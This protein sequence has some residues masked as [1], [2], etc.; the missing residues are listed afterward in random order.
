MHGFSIPP[1]GK[2]GGRINNPYSPHTYSPQIFSAMDTKSSVSGPNSLK[3]SSIYIKQD[4]NKKIKKMPVPT[5]SGSDQTE[6]LEFFPNVL[7]VRFPT[8]IANRYDGILT[9]CTKLC[10][11]NFPSWLSFG[12]F[13]F[14][15]ADMTTLSEL[16]TVISA[17]YVNFAPG[18]SWHG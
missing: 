10:V 8:A 16:G 3:H 6:H 4:L 2:D 17:E 14:L 9:F 1:Y 7:Q 18:A 15:M 11:A 13:D 12:C 5:I